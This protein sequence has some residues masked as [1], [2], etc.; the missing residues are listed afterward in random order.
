MIKLFS[1][2]YSTRNILLVLCEV[3]VVAGSFLLSALYWAGPDTY[4]VL[5]YEYGLIKIAGITLCTMLLIYYF[6]LYEPQR[7]P[8]RWEILFRLLLVLSVLTFLLAGTLYFFP[9][10]EL[11]PYALE[12]GVVVL[13]IALVLWRRFYDWTSSLSYFRERVYVLGGGERAQNIIDT[14]RDR[15]DA[16]I[17]VVIGK[18]STA[19][20]E[21]LASL[22]ADLRD[23]YEPKVSIDRI[24]VAMQDRRGAMPVRELLDLRLQGV[25]IEDGTS[26]M[27]R[28]SGKLSLNGLNP[29]AFIFTDGFKIKSSQQILR[30]VTSMGVSF[31]ALVILSP[32]LPFIMLAVRLSSP[33]PIFF[34][35]VRVGLRGRH[36]KLY[37]FRTMRQ[38]AEA[39]GAVWA[40]KNDPRVTRF[41][42]FMRRTRIDEIPQLW[43]VLRGDM[44]LIGPRPER[45]EFVQW[46]TSEIPYYE[47]RHLISP[48]VT[49]WAQVR[50]Q[51]GATLEET[52]RKLEYDLYYIKH[53]S[54]GIDLLVLFETLKTILLRR[55]SQ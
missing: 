29:S 24:I 6:D 27:E 16:G 48:G 53:L 17:D 34:K 14:L 11:C 13:S 41:G 25:R 46:L 19:P 31:V 52:K 40:L 37:K 43:N 15:R 33:G 8:Q 44:A 42:G 35:Q 36:F 54:M 1:V 26:F 5:M 21:D 28:L 10:F 30:R 22:S 38:D 39:G 9:Q 50:Y 3:L 4:I 49:G 55:G 18:H 20:G 45:P 2:Y 7:I 12:T 23:F 47:L 51:Y 32:F